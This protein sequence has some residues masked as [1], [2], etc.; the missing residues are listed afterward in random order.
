M[1][2]ISYT[3][4]LKKVV[5]VPVT[6]YAAGFVTA[7]YMFSARYWE[8]FFFT[9]F[10]ALAWLILKPWFENKKLIGAGDISI[11]TFL[12]PATWYVNP[13]FPVVFLLA[14]AATTLVWYRK[15]LNQS[16][17]KPMAPMMTIALLLTWIYFTL[18]GVL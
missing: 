18:T 3:D 14:W 8:F 1:V 7:A 10:F 2:R 9:I 11:L 6:L 16:T 5:E 4:W 15:E 17:E 13:Y 12:L